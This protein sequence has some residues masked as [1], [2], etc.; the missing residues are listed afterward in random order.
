MPRNLAMT[1]DQSKSIHDIN[2]SLS[3]L[4]SALE[5]INDEWK[6]NQ[7]LVEKIVPLTQKKLI[8]LQKSLT[9]YYNNH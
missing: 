9:D 5:L 7:Q 8:E 3:S 1:K 6:N 4:I 2:A